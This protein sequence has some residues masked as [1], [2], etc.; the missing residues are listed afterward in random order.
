MGGH[1]RGEMNWEIGIDVCAL[2]CIKQ[3]ASGNMLCTTGC[4]AQWSMGTQ[5][6]GMGEGREV[7]QGGDVYTHR[8]FTSFTAEINS[9][10]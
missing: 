3:I 9:T 10:L 4:S 1:G 8:R 7:H 5:M 6:G 2:L